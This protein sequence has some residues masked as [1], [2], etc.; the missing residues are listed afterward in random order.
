M[1]RSWRESRRGRTSASG[2]LLHCLHL[3]SQTWVSATRGSISSCPVH[4]IGQGA[5]G[6]LEQGSALKSVGTEAA[7]KNMPTMV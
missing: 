2:H 4:A 3:L 1:H 7:V 6:P 5:S